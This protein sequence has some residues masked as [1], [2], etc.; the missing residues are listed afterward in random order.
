MKSKS[1]ILGLLVI[2]MACKQEKRGETEKQAEVMNPSPVFV[3]DSAYAFVQKQVDFG[4]R[5]PNTAAHSACG[6]YLVASLTRFGWQVQEQLFEM[7]AYTGEKLALRN[8][9][10]SINP[11]EKKRILLAAHWDTRP[12]A[13][14][15]AERQKEP[16]D[17]ANDGGSG[18]GVL[19]EIARVLGAE[20]PEVGVDIILFDGEDYGEAMFDA[21]NAPYTNTSWYCLGS[22]YWSKNKHK[23]GYSAYYGILL[24]MVG[25]KDA[26]FYQEGNS[27][28]YAP[29]IVY[30]VWETA[31]AI[32][33]DHHFVNRKTYGIT[34]DHYFVN[35]IGKIPMID[36]IEYDPLNPESYFPDYHHTHKDNMDIISRETLK[37]VGQTVIQ[38][39]VNE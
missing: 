9:I 7:E 26:L 3:A 2:T 35:T 32:G 13:D 5:V 23:A 39:V 4:P 27:L 21:G 16:I 6:D 17:G 22:Q 14:K 12:F 37:A 29:S 31:S 1:I 30:K 11:E 19:L 24:D 25:A 33:Y 15:D 8:I 18:V 28:E 20:K 36:I 34:D 38:T 10:A